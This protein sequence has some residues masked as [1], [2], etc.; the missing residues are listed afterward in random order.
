M[1]KKT[2][3]IAR[4]LEKQVLEAIEPGLVT[5]Q[6]ANE[7]LAELIDILEVAGEALADELVHEKP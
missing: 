1:S 6:E 7:I 2:D 5:K 3:A 4:A